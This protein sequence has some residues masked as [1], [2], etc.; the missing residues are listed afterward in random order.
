MF[1]PLIFNILYYNLVVDIN[2]YIKELK[3]DTSVNELVLKEKS[4]ML[5][6]LKA[7][8]V[9]RL[10]T[11]KNTLSDLEKKKKRLLK[12]IIPKV[13]ESLPVKLNESVIRDSAES[14]KEVNDINEKIEEQKNIIDF[15]ERTEKIMSSF[16]FDI[17]NIVK[18]V[19]LETL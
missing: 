11:H 16:S 9:S 18:V 15:L 3:E 14:T 12:S 8:W 13:R 10:I 17:S 4:L 1:S 2:S 6:G 7:K 5:P 19:Q